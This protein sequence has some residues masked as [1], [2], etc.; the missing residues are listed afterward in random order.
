MPRIRRDY[1]GTLKRV[2]GANGGRTREET[3][4]CGEEIVTCSGSSF[5]G[6]AY[7]LEIQLGSGSYTTQCDTCPI[8][9]QTYQLAYSNESG[10]HIY[11]K[12][13]TFG[14]TCPGSNPIRARRLT[15]I[16]RATCVGGVVFVGNNTL[17]GVSVIPTNV[18]VPTFTYID[19]DA[20]GV[21]GFNRSLASSIE[22]PDP[23]ILGQWSGWKAT[24]AG[25]TDPGTETWMCEGGSG[26]QVRARWI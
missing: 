7:N 26:M 6:S 21:L 22:F 16:C 20:N 17:G 9:T 2:R 3:C 23:P 11:Y 18:P 24:S 1:A 5:V 19:E 12:R 14:I 25:T 4:C 15:I 10:Q 13:T 8:E